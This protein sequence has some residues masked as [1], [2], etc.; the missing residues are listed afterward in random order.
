MINE[1]CCIFRTRLTSYEAKSLV[2]LLHSKDEVLLEKALTTIG[3]TGTFEDNQVSI[4]AHV[5]PKIVGKNL[6]HFCGIAEVLVS[7]S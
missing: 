2:A 6:A 3:N 1:N 4:S 7:L 5:F